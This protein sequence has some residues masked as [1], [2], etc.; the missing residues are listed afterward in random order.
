VTGGFDFKD[1]KIPPRPP[2]NPGA[3]ALADSWNQGH[4]TRH[5]TRLV[6]GT[7]AVPPTRKDILQH[8]KAVQ[9]IHN[10][11]PLPLFIAES[12]AEGGSARPTLDAAAGTAEMTTMDATRRR[13]TRDRARQQWYARERQRRFARF[14]GFVCGVPEAPRADLSVKS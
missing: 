3:A 7:Q 6:V 12:V 9:E 2:P 13:R 8:G 5:F 10:Y 11:P 14:M 1:P 4:F